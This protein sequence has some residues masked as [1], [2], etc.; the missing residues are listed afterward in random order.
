MQSNW[1]CVIS[2]LA[3]FIYQFDNQSKYYDKSN[4]DVPN[5]V[6]TIYFVLTLKIALTG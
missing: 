4:N 3:N 2:H 6:I 1:Y 5:S